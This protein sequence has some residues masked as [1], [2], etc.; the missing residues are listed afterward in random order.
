[1]V[2]R[3]GEKW[4]SVHI[5]VVR[6]MMKDD[7]KASAISVIS[8]SCRRL[9]SISWLIVSKAADKSSSAIIEPY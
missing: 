4:F 1:M 3:A 9:M 5:D 2:V 6:P 7:S 8:I